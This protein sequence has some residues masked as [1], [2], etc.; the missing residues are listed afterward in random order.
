ML[1]R[2]VLLITAVTVTAAVTAGP[3]GAQSPTD[4]PVPGV[5]PGACV[6]QSRPSSR[7]SRTKA[8]RAGRAH[9]LNGTAS[10]VGCGVDRVR[11][12][13]SLKKGN[14]CRSLKS[15]GRL[16]TRAKCTRLH[17]LA[18][19]GT[20]KWSFRLSKRLTKGQYRIR[21]RATD[22]AGNVQVPR[23]HRLRFR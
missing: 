4:N 22:F 19:K 15:N 13:V 10:D 21:T 6:D 23:V 11:I 9:T 7:F 5:K 20:T 16:G 2:F 1:T 17:W 12:S 3:A 8:F 14:R 18:V